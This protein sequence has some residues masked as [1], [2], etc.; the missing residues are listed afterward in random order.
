VFLV[1]D[2]SSGLYLGCEICAFADLGL[3]AW[4]IVWDGKYNYML[5]KFPS[6]G[7]IGRSGIV[8][9]P[10]NRCGSNKYV[11]FY[12]SFDGAINNLIRCVIQDDFYPCLHPKEV[13]S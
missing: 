13:Y 6:P 10:T 1:L 12:T 9:M 5:F 3:Y 8:R 11:E 4:L 7:V 2:L